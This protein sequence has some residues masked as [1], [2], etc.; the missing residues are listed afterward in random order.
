MGTDRLARAGI[1]H[2]RALRIDRRDHADIERALAGG[3]EGWRLDVAGIFLAARGAMEF[4]CAGVLM[5]SLRA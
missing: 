4:H 5:P 1:E 2:H 3:I